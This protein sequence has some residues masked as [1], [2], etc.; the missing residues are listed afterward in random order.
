MVAVSG[1]ADSVFLYHL[2]KLIKVEYNL[3]LIVCH[4]NHMIRGENADSDEEFVKN[5]AAS[6]GDKVYSK[7][8]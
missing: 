2:L 8:S 5:L 7:R 4:V 6:S 1:G 3:E